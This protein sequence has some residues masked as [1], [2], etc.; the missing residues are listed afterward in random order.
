MQIFYFPQVS[1]NALIC[2]QCTENVESFSKFYSEIQKQ[3]Q[4]LIEES[5][6]KDEEVQFIILV[7]QQTEEN[8]PEQVQEPRTLIFSEDESQPNDTELIDEKVHASKQ[9][10]SS[11]TNLDEFPIHIIEDGKLIPKGKQLTKMISK[12]YK[13]ECDLCPVKKKFRKF[14]AMSTHFRNVHLSKSH[15][16][17]CNMKITKLRQIALHMARH[18]QPS[19]FK[20]TICNKLLT[21]PKILTLH[22]QNHLPEEKRRLACPENGCNRRFAYQSALVNHSLSHLSEEDRAS[23]SCCDKKF[24]NSSRL[25]SHIA[26][27][28]STH[29]KREFICE[30][31]SKTFTTKSN[32]S[33]HLTTHTQDFQV[34]CELCGKWLKNKVCLRKHMTIHSETKHNCDKC[35]YSSANKQC[36]INH[37]KVHHSEEKPFRCEHC[38]NSFKLKNTLINHVNGMHKG[39]R[40]YHCEF[41]SKTFVSSGN[42]KFSH[43][44][45][46][47]R[48]SHDFLSIQTQI[49]H[50]V[51]EFIQKS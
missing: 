27:S 48:N 24:A 50:T 51:R 20:C 16:Y 47:S 1:Q 17:C 49:M 10:S 21:S 35:N 23:F 38:G 37:Q 42:C 4:I 45:I 3:Q 9:D 33:Y 31:C 11:L 2:G 7:E 46:N 15:V 44:T 32:L 13:L 25:K 28:H 36:L 41:C 8:K 6:K 5:R 26:N 14:S 19:A 18:I 39:I 34:Q 29:E 43:F 22:L 12:F 30:I 40:K